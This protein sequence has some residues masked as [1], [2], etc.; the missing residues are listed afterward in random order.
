[1]RL[2][3][4][5]ATIGWINGAVM[6]L[7]GWHWRLHQGGVLDLLFFLKPLEAEGWVVRRKDSIRYPRIGLMTEERS[8][9][10]FSCIK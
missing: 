9:G 1:M 6:F 5:L 8:A 2:T 7:L 4:P 3:F 10:W